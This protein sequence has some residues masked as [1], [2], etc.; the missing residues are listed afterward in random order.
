MTRN[1]HR[2]LR[3]LERAIV[4]ARAGLPTLSIDTTYT[5][6][7]LLKL[8]REV[9]LSIGVGLVAP[10]CGAFLWGSASGRRWIPIGT[11]M[12]T[13]SLFRSLAGIAIA[14]TA[15]LMMEMRFAGALPA[16][17]ERERRTIF[18]S[19]C[20]GGAV[21]IGCAVAGICLTAHPAAHRATSPDLVDAMFGA[22]IYGTFMIGALLVLLA[23]VPRAAFKTKVASEEKWLRAHGLRSRR[24]DLPAKHYLRQL[25]A[26][27][28]LSACLLAGSILEWR[29]SAVA[30]IVAG[31]W[32]WRA[33]IS[34]R[35]APRADEGLPLHPVTLLATVLVGV[36][37]PFVA[38]GLLASVEPARTQTAKS[39]YEV[40]AGAL[41]IG[42]V[43]FAAGHPPDLRTR[44][45]PG[46]HI[47][48]IW[49]GIAMLAGL[50][51]VEATLAADG[52]AGWFAFWA[53]VTSVSAMLARIPLLL[54]PSVRAQPKTSG[55]TRQ[56]LIE[57]ALA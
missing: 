46:L 47:V 35:H 13:Q 57:A 30:L 34:Q 38:H 53:T 2:R 43:A 8:A 42:F 54:S 52:G 26:A 45:L 51:L 17:L 48:G 56:E 1:E 22:S 21:T 15:A 7:A 10:S 19:F 50:G 5:R 6:A 4:D 18:R 25:A 32:L 23:A 49:C 16:N 55:R 41:G 14:L 12:A 27:G 3:A 31:I 36:S 28:T 39:L 20:L 37:V 44:L 9:T 40:A 24:R 33:V 11:G 29:I